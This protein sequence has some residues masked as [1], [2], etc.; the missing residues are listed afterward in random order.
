MPTDEEL[1]AQ[2][3]EQDAAA[4]A[5]EDAA[6]KAEAD[7]AKELGEKGVAALREERT[8]RRAAEKA[9]KDAADKLAALQKQSDEAAAAKARADE[10]AAAKKGEWEKLATERAETLKARDADLKTVID[11][12][13]A[14][15]ARIEAFEKSEQERFNAA[16][17]T[18]T[19]DLKETDPINF[20]PNASLEA[21]TKW[22]DKQSAKAGIVNGFRQPRTPVPTTT[23]KPEVKSLVTNW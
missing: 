4:K 7:E 16:L 5:A 9:A 20:D 21:R 2:K 3:A 14:L 15:K 8:Q 18:L 10:E 19:D 23:T 17:A 13:D 1:A 12:R 11:E 6:A 22:L